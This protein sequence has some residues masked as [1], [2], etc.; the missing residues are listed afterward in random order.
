[1]WLSTNKVYLYQD[2]RNFQ[3]YLNKCYSKFWKIKD[4]Y[5]DGIIGIFINIIDILLTFNYYQ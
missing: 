5:P 2:I 1:M 4:S 3:P